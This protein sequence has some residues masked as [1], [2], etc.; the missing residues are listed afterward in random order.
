MF[1]LDC[2][3][4][5]NPV[6]DI[7]QIEGGFVMALGYFLQEQVVFSKASGDLLTMGTWEYKPANAQD[8]PSVFNVTLMKDMYNNSGILGSKA[9]AEPCMV[10]ANSIYFAVNMA[11][12]A[13][14][15][16]A[17]R[18]D[19]P[20]LPVPTTIAVRQQANLVSPARFVMPKVSF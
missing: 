7:G 10:L 18:C 13:A 5:L 12:I 8:I 1:I 15:A 14:R 11:V 6:V 19:F 16:D 3:Q 9:T 2:G 20:G 17:G 4:S